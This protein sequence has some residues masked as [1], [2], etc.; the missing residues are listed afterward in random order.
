[1]DSALLS[2]AV[3]LLRAHGRLH[4]FLPWGHH[5]LCRIDSGRRP[6][7]PGGESAL[8]VSVPRVYEKVLAKVRENVAVSPP[9]KQ[10]I[11]GWAVDVARQ[12]LPYR[13]QRRTPSGR[14]RDP[15]LAGRQAGLWQDQGAPWQPLS[16]RHLGRG[17]PGPR[18]R[19]VL[20]GR[21]DRDLRGIR[22]VGD[23]ARTLCQRPRCREARDRRSR[24]S[25]SGAEN[26][27]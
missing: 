3:P 2:A 14:S 25:G 8:F 10:K 13:L 24:D 5:R 4:L 23:L 19:R 7:L 15:A 27:R 21:R 20:L 1:M 26:R 6:E 11:F 12:A 17:P 22:P 18:S 16:V 9:L